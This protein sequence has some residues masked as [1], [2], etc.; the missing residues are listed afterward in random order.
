MKTIRSIIGLTTLF[1]ALTATTFAQLNITV[2]GSSD[3]TD[4]VMSDTFSGTAVDSNKWTTKLPYADSRVEVGGSALTS[5]NRAYINSV[6]SFIGDVEI[7]FMV[8]SRH[9][10]R[11]T[12]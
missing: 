7:S 4:V 10:P 3:G 8:K 1:T 9:L 2:L 12:D 11:L 6:D 5:H